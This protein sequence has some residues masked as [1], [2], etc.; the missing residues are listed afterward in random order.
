MSRRTILSFFGAL[1]L[2]LTLSA[3]CCWDDH[4]HWHDHG[5][6]GHYGGHHGH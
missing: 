4:G 5:H 2:A 3:C 1:L 6:G